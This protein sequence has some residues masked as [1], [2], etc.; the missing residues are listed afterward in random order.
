MR[1]TLIS[2]LLLAT[3]GCATGPDYVRPQAPS[4]NQSAFVTEA[5]GTTTDAAPN[6]EW[7]RIYDDP[8]LETLIERALL[9]NTDLRVAM[10]N[11]TAAEAVIGEARN[12]RLPQTTI[13]GQGSYG[14]TQPPLFLPGNRFTGMGGFQLS[15]EADLFG[16]VSRTIEAARADAGAAA[17]ARAAVQVRIV[18]AVT[19]A[20]LS[21]CTASEAMAAVQSSIDLTTES[22]RIIRQQ[23]QAGSAATLD[24]ARAEGQLAEARAALAPFENA[25]QVA[26]FELAALLGLPPVQAPEAAARCGSAPDPHR[27]IPVGDAVSLLK[28]RP[29][30]AEAE[31][32]LAAATARIGVATADL[33]PRISFGASVAQAGGERISQG[34]GFVFGVGPLLSFSFPNN[35][36]ARARIRQ[37]EARA[38]AALAT[39]DGVVLTAMKEAEQSLSGY[40]AAL[41]RQGDLR[42]AEQQANQAFRL[43]DLRYRAGSIAYIDVIVAQS[44]L[45]RAKLALAEQNRASASALVTLFRALGGGWTPPDALADRDGRVG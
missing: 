14:R 38:E 31:R 42:I 15:Y 43:A 30:V 13:T 18:A 44:E 36:V 11:L 25:R 33:Y 27:P 41:R 17:F 5:P 37:S 20:Y 32:R 12:A 6:V 9:A 23:E 45:V 35:G 7:W 19:D 22:A 24:V 21:A 28:R 1:K 16:R 2:L 26:I 40:A 3:S 29:D 39:F 10:A 8:A 4:G 34:Q